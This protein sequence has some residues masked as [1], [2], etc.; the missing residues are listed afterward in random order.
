MQAMDT[1]FAILPGL[2]TNVGVSDRVPLVVGGA[3][4]ERI[5]DGGTRRPALPPEP[6][7]SS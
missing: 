2:G 7:V 1:S 4:A 3:D 5:D 6:A